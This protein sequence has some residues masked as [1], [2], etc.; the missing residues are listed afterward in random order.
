MSTKETI[1]Q[2][3]T[4][5]YQKRGKGSVY[6]KNLLSRKISIPFQNI[7]GNIK[8]N[9]KRTL[10]ND[11]YNKCSKEGYIK[12]NS[13]N[14]I[15]YSSGLVVSNDVMFDVLFECLLCHPVEGQIIKCKVLNITR[16]GLRATYAKE[17]VSPI[18]VFIARDHHFK[19]EYFAKIKEEEEINIK[20]I[21][22]RYELHDKT[23]SIL[24]E[25]KIPKKSKMK[26]KVIIE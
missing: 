19:N 26:T 4:K 24:G 20:V 2:K 6:M 8:E 16:A 7:G 5:S 15:S 17:E 18:T 9:I 22:I 14:I 10:E 23:I 3:T 21:G 25:L 13:I 12:T 1:T 11:L